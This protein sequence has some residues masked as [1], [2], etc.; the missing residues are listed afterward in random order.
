MAKRK[1]GKSRIADVGSRKER[2]AGAAA[3]KET[4]E[5]DAE[6]NPQSAEAAEGTRGSRRTGEPIRHP[7]STILP[8]AGLFA[9]ALLMFFDV[10]FAGGTRVLGMQGADMY[11]QFVAWRDFGF[12]ELAHGNLALWNPH[13]YSGAPYFGGMQAALLYP[14]NVIFLILPLAAAINWSVALH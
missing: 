2:A 1:Q 10:L 3:G 5:G 13:I 11:L 8:L 9:L 7:Q 14:P 12:R 6:P 4:G